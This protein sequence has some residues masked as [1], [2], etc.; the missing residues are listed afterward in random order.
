MPKRYSSVELIE[1]VKAVGWL[2][3]SKNG[4]HLKFKHS[5]KPGIV[6]IPHPKKDM[7]TGTAQKILKMASLKERR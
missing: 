5:K 6:V 4:S 2:Q 1:I 3:V 7:P